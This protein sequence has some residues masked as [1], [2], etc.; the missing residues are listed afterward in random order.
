MAARIIGSV[1]ETANITFATEPSAYDAWGRAFGNSKMGSTRGP[2]P[3][4][5]VPTKYIITKG[6]RMYDYNSGIVS[7]RLK[8]AIESI[9]PGIHQFHPVTVLHKD[10]SPTTDAF[11]ALYICTNIDAILSTA[12]VKKIWYTS[13]PEED[14]DRYGWDVV[15]PPIGDLS[16]SAAVTKGRAIWVDRRMSYIDM[17]VSDAMRSLYTSHRMT[18]WEERD[19]WREA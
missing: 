3:S 9:E 12:G 11:W 19:F 13:T 2:V 5:V 4:D 18:G 8:E 7:A 10:G 15:H 16:V 14:P 1:Y 17:F 6:R